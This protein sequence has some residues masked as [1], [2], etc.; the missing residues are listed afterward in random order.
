[1]KKEKCK[2][3][4]RRKG[5]KCVRAERDDDDD[6]SAVNMITTM[7]AIGVADGIGTGLPP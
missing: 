7:A 3:G 5:K 2:K 6:Y 4:F 1:M